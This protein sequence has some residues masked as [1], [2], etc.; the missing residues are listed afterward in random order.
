[1][2]NNNKDEAYGYTR[3]PFLANISILYPL[4]TPKNQCFLLLSG[5]GGYKM[6]LLAR[7]GLSSWVSISLMANAIPAGD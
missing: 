5:G 4:K 1:M 6:R 7:N 2:E 3:E